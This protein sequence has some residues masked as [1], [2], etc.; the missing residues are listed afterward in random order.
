MTAYFIL[1]K[2]LGQVWTIDITFNMNLFIYSLQGMRGAQG[3][4]GKPGPMV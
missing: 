4:V 3:N 2:T 1:K